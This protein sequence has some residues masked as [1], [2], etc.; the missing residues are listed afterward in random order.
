M[1][2]NFDMIKAYYN[3]YKGL[4]SWTSG[5]RSTLCLVLIII[6]P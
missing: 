1:G 4:R 2:M 3:E 6:G 5:A